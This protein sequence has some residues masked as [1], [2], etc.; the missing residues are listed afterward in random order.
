MD[1][2]SGAGGERPQADVQRPPSL[3]TAA[4]YEYQPRSRWKVTAAQLM[5]QCHQCLS[6]VERLQRRQTLLLAIAQKARQ[7]R[8]DA[9][10]TATTG[11]DQPV[12]FVG[13]LRLRKDRG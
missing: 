2:A 8:V 4:V 11:V 10:E 12:A 9:R 7:L 1:S 13:A 3:Q 6:G 5:P